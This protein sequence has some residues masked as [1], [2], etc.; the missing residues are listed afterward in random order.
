MDQEVRPQR[1]TEVNGVGNS[2]N[3]I[4][5][6]GAGQVLNGVATAPLRNANAP[7]AVVHIGTGKLATTIQVGNGMMNA[8]AVDHTNAGNAFTASNRIDMNGYGGV[9]DGQIPGQV[10]GQ[11]NGGPKGHPNEVPVNDQENRRRTPALSRGDAFHIP[12]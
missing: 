6:Q 8:N 5:H 12:N 7:Q 9:S 11:P 3:G 4:G 2:F 1:A 10:P